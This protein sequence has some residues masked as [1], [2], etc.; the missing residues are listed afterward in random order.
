M[1]LQP[2]Q[3]LSHYR[4]VEKIGEGG[5]GVVWKAKDTRLHREVAIKVLPEEFAG[6]IERLAR[7]E[8]EAKA[9]AALNHPHIVTLFNIENDGATHFLTMELVEGT[10]LDRLLSAGGLALAQV[11]DIGI[12]L[13]EA[14]AAAHEKGI[15]HRDLKP[16]NVMLTSDRRVKVLDFGL[17][18]LATEAVPRIDLTQAITQEMPITA[19]GVILG[20]LPYMSPEQVQG[21]IVD[22]RTDIFSLGVVLYELST[23]ERPFR[24]DSQ[25]AL[26]SSIMTKIPSLVTEKRTGLPRSL[27]HIIQRCLEKDPRAR[28]QTSVE[29]SDHLKHLRREIRSAAEAG[30]TIKR[31]LRRPVV[32]ALMTMVLFGVAGL[33]YLPYRSRLNL[34][35]ARIL[36]AEVERLATSGN[37]AE[38]FERAVK[39]EEIVPDDP[40]LMRWLPEIADTISISTVPE[41]AIVYLQ[42]FA[43]ESENPMDRVRVGMTPIVDLRIARSDHLLW[44]EKEGYTTLE[45][46]VS[47]ALNRAERRLGVEPDLVLEEVLVAR[48]TVPDDMVLVP[49]GEYNLRGSG[50]RGMDAVT[51]DDFLVDRHEVS[52]KNFLEFVQAGGYS[53][54]S[55]WQHPFMKDSVELSFD[56]AMAVL[57][58]R[59]GLPGP[60]E[61]SN[62]EFPEGQ[63]NHPVT[64]VTW[65]EAA[66]YAEYTGKVL[67]TIYQWE[68]AARGGRFTHFEGIVM[69]WGLMNMAGSSARR[70]N[71]LARGTAAVNDYP[72]GI[73]PYGAYNMGGNVEEWCLNERSAGRATA[74]G[75]WADAPY[76]FP[77]GGARPPFQSSNTTGFRRVSKPAPGAA[78]QGTGRI[79]PRRS[80]VEFTPVDDATY[81]GFLS[82]YRYD[83]KPLGAEVVE[84]IDTPDWT[85]Q[86]L[87]FSGVTDDRIIAYL[88]LPK[89]AEPPYQC[90][91]YVVS[92][93]VFFGRT[94]A[95][96]VEAILSPQIKAGRAVMAVVPRGAIERE[97]P[98]HS[99]YPAP[100]QWDTVQ[101][102]AMVILRVTE[103]RMGL[104]Y[105]QSR[106]EIDMSRIA[107]IGF[108]WGATERALILTAVEPRIQSSIFVGGGIWP[109]RSL[110]E[111]TAV[112]F[113]PRIRG[114]VLVLTGRYDETTPYEPNARA[115][116]QLV[117]APK[118]L[119]LTESGHLPPLELRNPIINSFLDRTLGSVK[120]SQGTNTP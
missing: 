52:N 71:Y 9:V 44:L 48:G 111:V 84:V 112:N 109:R 35:R 63:G 27:G 75:S 79:E 93:T 22:A 30:Q 66:A 103:F 57:Q 87:T 25:A 6:D 2:G 88:Y 73:S 58:D 94:V 108:S 32:I 114:P 60:R 67:P 61:W 64:G 115:L 37:Y 102:R 68:K 110:P 95:E 12:A 10:G 85:R 69:P 13:A 104:D 100:G 105:L 7:F 41:G 106:K 92:S 43:D 47:S 98:G 78:D 81:Q 24:G 15:I 50:F 91:N 113:V 33:V 82:H 56:Q 51:L 89:R 31:L 99:N 116:F 17:A 77:I 90:I 20:T 21:K 11:L 49:G 86:K 97:W 42:R 40:T 4:L 45:R 80:A 1:P 23:G 29:V 39:A 120:P 74:G 70:A 55:Y 14:L 119:E 101:T 117:K 65:Y 76:V 72:F 36:V 34:E 83:K 53:N 107:H 16:G 3:M 5:M 28:F 8:R 54:P 26:I 59:S 18:K 62:Q 38:A 19:K 118:Q 96:E 46:V